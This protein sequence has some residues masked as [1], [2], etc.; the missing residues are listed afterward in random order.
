MQVCRDCSGAEAQ[1]GDHRGPERHGQGA[2]RHVLQVHRCG[3]PLH[4]ITVHPR[5][6]LGLRRGSTVAS[7]VADPDPHFLGFPDPHPLVRGMVPR[8]RIRTKISWVTLVT[9]TVTLAKEKCSVP[10]P[11]PALQ[12]LSRSQKKVFSKL[13]AYHLP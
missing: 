9:S 13:F 7:S 11:D 5:A 8:I 6:K 1:A 4:F 10:D 2:A 3:T 12:L